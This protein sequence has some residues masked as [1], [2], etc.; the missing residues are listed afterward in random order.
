MLIFHHG[1][2]SAGPEQERTVTPA[3]D[4]GFQI[5][6]IVRPGYLNSDP[7]PGRKLSDVVTWHQALLAH[8]EVD[9]FV[10][11]GYSGGGPYALASAALMRDY[12][13]GLV[14]LAGVGPAHEPTLDF[15]AGTAPGQ[16]KASMFPGDGSVNALRE[17][18]I[19]DQA[20]VAALTKEEFIKG[21]DPDGPDGKLRLESAD[22]VYEGYQTVMASSLEGLVDDAVNIREPWEF[23]IGDITAPTVIGCGEKDTICPPSHSRWFASRISHAKTIFTSEDGHAGIMV[24]A[25]PKALKDLAARQ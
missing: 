6:E 17:Q 14:V 23:N 20:Q 2:P 5:A 9:E 21:I 16:G 4:A 8:L 1:I 22:W 11:A 15:D 19:M 18:T 25:Y 24:S 7:M 3:L 12:C 13:Q 10:V